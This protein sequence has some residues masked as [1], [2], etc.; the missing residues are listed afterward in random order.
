MGTS[1]MKSL[2]ES[3]W[4]ADRWCMR[5]NL[6]FFFLTVPKGEVKKAG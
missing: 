2:M 1:G 6:P 3:P 4:G 5:L